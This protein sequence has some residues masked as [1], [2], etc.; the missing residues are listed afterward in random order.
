[1]KHRSCAITFRVDANEYDDLAKA[2]VL[3]GAHSMSELVRVS[4]TKQIA[5]N[6]KD[7]VVAEYLEGVDELLAPFEDELRDFRRYL[8]QVLQTLSAGR[9]YNPERAISA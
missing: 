2:A 6:E 5:A 8:R 7:H 4:I 9:N 3:R 1:M